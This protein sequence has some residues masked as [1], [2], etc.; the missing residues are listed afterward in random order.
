[1]I[2]RG[3]IEGCSLWNP[4]GPKSTRFCHQKVGKD[5]LPTP[6]VGSMSD[7]NNNNNNKR[8][9]KFLFFK[10]IVICDINSDLTPSLILIGSF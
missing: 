2:P 8:R 6:E 1:M 5:L 4:K 9:G 10:C 7:N 3:S